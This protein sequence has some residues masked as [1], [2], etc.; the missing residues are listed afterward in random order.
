MGYIFTF[1]A[2]SVRDV[3]WLSI[4]LAIAQIA[5][6]VYQLVEV[7]YD[8]VFWNAI[9]T[10]V[11]IYYI[12]RIIHDRKPVKTPNAIKDI[13]EKKYFQFKHKRIYELLEF[14]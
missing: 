2:L 7:R 5:M 9:F 13:Y 4:I 11:N 1:F 8:I 10:V 6:G 12:A 3:L 14:K